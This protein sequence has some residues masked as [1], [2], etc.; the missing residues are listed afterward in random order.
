MERLRQLL[1]EYAGLIHSFDTDRYG[2]DDL[3][4]LE[5]VVP[6]PMYSCK[7]RRASRFARALESMADSM[8]FDGAVCCAEACCDVQE[9]SM[10]C[11]APDDADRE[12]HLQAQVMTILRALNVLRDAGAMDKLCASLDDDMLAALRYMRRQ[13]SRL[14][15]DSRRRILLPDY[16]KEIE[17]P[18]L[19]KALYLLFLAHPE[20]IRLKCL[21]DYQI[22]LTRLYLSLTNRGDREQAI[23]A[24]EAL[25]YPGA[26]VLKTTFSRMN[27]AFRKALQADVAEYYTVRGLN[28][29]PRRIEL[30][31][32]LISM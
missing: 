15:I 27:Q 31:R 32:D 4:E 22:E 10:P 25:C 23:A 13:P 11:P 21:S 18:P 1:R 16:N 20:G 24:V 9:F 8:D 2:E 19:S 7:P 3:S 6:R 26:D 14:V 28:G 30:P 17:M 29:E 12:Q 5:Q